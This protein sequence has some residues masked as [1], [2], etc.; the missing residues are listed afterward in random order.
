MKAKTLKE[1]RTERR[2]SKAELGRRAGLNYTTVDLV[3]RGR[4]RPYPG[5][6]QK[7]ARALGVRADEVSELT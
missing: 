7:L 5:Q 2:L 6:V 4:L 1:I 3:E